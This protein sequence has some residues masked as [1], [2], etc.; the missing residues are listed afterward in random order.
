LKIVC[1]SDTHSLHVRI[2]DIPAGD[3]LII[4]GDCTNVGEL[5]DLRRFNEW[6]GYLS[7]KRILICGGNHDFCF[8]HERE[9]SVSILTN[10]TYLQDQSITI[11]GFKFYASPW[12]PIFCDWAFMLTAAQLK[13]KWNE[14][15]VDTD[16]LVTHAPPF[17]F[18]DRNLEG[19]PCGC[20]ELLKAVTSIKPRV[21]VFGHIH[22][23]Y[24]QYRNKHTRFYNVSTCTR[25][26]RPTNPPVVIDLQKKRK[27]K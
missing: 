8:E 12:S 21:H 18:G 24:G 1:I 15:P 6:L 16:V 9:K 25:Q 7:F 14:I 3:V 11:D 27:R 13:E 19:Y 26:Y 4:A 5:D 2:E 22:E 20:S 17:G 10:G 23:G